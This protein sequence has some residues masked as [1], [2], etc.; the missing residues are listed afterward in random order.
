MPRRAGS[1][2]LERRASQNR[3]EKNP[4]SARGREGALSQH[5]AFPT[6]TGRM[7]FHLDSWFDDG[8]NWP[9]AE[10]PPRCLSR[11]DSELDRPC[12][13]YSK[14][15]GQ[16]NIA[17]AWKPSCMVR[18]GLHRLHLS[19]PRPSARPYCPA[20]SPQ[21]TGSSLDLGDAGVG[22]ACVWLAGKCC[23]AFGLFR[24]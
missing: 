19:Y 14:T 3:G 20:I 4:T 23:P 5:V 18:R 2:A 7:V 6:L 22:A 24:G 9:T 16:V 8:W 15:V 13:A 10:A 11:Q 1:P 17:T 21:T 12:S